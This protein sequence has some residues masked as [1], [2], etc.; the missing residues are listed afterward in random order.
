M[1]KKIKIQNFQSHQKSVLKLHPGV[2]I[3]VG[4][5]DTGKTAVLRALRWIIWNRPVGDGF[6][7]HWGGKTLVRIISNGN[8]IER[9]KDKNAN[10]YQLDDKKFQAIKTTV[11]EEVKTTLNLSDVNLQRQHD[12]PFLLTD[13]PGDVAKHFNKI[14][15]LDVIDTS[16]G[17]IMSWKRATVKKIE[18]GKSNLVQF[19]A[20]KK[21]F[22]YLKDLEKIVVDI[23][24]KDKALNVLFNDSEE[25]LQLSLEIVDVGSGITSHQEI[26]AAENDVNAIIELFAARRRLKLSRKELKGIMFELRELKNDIQEAEELSSAGV[27]VQEL[28]DMERKYQVQKEDRVNLTSIINHLNHVKEMKENYKESL[29]KLEQKY[30]ENFPDICPLCNTKLK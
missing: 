27:P 4:T 23:E 1:I 24:E 10:Y 21:R 14:A 28:I 5:S 11:P 19:K 8:S 30:V 15:H 6:R 3:I 25:L 7:S 13:T 26:T 18:A 12:N 22:K 29:Q 9:V 16:V 17:N 20:E 2:N